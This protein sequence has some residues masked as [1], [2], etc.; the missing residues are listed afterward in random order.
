MMAI[1][2]MYVIAAAMVASLGRT[3]KNKEGFWWFF[4]VSLILTPFIGLIVVMATDP[5]DK[6]DKID[7]QAKK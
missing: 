3:R 6:H 7:K 4:V 5:I 1:V 2:F